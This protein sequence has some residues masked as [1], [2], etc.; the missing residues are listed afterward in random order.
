[1]LQQ[2]L[3]P[4]LYQHESLASWLHR[5]RTGNG[6]GNWNSLL[7][8]N[9]SRLSPIVNDPDLHLK[10]DHYASLEKMSDMEVA[11]Q[12]AHSLRTWEGYLVNHFA[13]SGTQRWLLRGS[14]KRH[15]RH[16]PYSICIECLKTDKTSFYRNYWRLSIY[17]VCHRHRRLMI[18][19]CYRCK[20][21]I[22][23]SQD[24]TARLEVCACCGENLLRHYRQ[25][26]VIAHSPML[27]SILALETSIVAQSGTDLPA[28]V[29]YEFLKFD[30]LYAILSLINRRRFSEKLFTLPLFKKAL[31][32]IHKTPSDIAL[33]F[34]A[35]SNRIRYNML[36]MA[37][38]L[39]TDWPHRFVN[40]F[41]EAKI[42]SSDIYMN[43]MYLPYWL[44][45]VIRTSLYRPKYVMS[46]QEVMGAREVLTKS[47]I[48]VTRVAIERL[49]GIHDSR[50]LE[51]Q[52]PKVLFSEAD[53][54]SLLQELR[55]NILNTASARDARASLIR[56]ATAIIYAVAF[57]LPVQEICH[58][59][60]DDALEMWRDFM[61]SWS[62]RK[63]LNQSNQ[64]L[65]TLAEFGE[66]WLA[67]YV[68]FV[69]H[70][71]LKHQS[72]CNAFLLT[73]FGNAFAGHGLHDRFIR[74]LQT[75]D[76]PQAQRGFRVISDIP[77]W[78]SQ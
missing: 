73:R 1:M 52:H 8:E 76:Y 77:K 74:L 70:R 7:I 32:E 50:R 12:Q 16:L 14:E 42:L 45:V 41:T 5:L 21:P 39:L 9:E 23:L 40:A 26:P 46:Q 43:Q 58:L 11:K 10:P 54:I 62:A 3:R 2:L 51:D 15:A 24:R 69:R 33:P 38:W 53:A 28:S 17:T 67:S 22:L 6:F 29:A 61:H 60:L 44:N 66:E 78:E 65:Q 37:I 59:E 55:E 68:Q 19:R 13:A 48:P 56:D 36:T 31:S 20:N 27:E 18:N 30:G 63:T 72:H 71:F 34:E 35:R 47:N 49:L 25:S 57:R 64:L 75:I 4:P